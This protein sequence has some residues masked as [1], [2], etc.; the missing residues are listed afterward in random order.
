M[1]GE[2]L[3]FV[4]AGRILGVEAKAVRRLADRGQLTIK[5]VPG[6]RPMVLASE[7]RALA[8][9]SIV[10]RAPNASAAC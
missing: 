7:V 2:W 9:S 8:K 10:K 6:C 4:G 3:S 5:H 1:T